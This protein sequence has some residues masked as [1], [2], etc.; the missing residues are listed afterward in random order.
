MIPNRI[1][2]IGGSTVYGQG[3]PHGGG[4]VGRLRAWHEGSSPE[5][6]RVFNLGIGGDGV[7]EMLFRGS[8]EISARRAELIILY[9]GLNDTRR[10]GSKNNPTQTELNYF[11]STLL[12]LITTLLTQA[13][14][15]LMSPVPIDEQKTCPYRSKWFFTQNDAAE[16]ANIIS[17]LAKE[18]NIPY[19]PVFETW[20][21]RSN[22]KNLLEDGLHCNSE[23]HQLLFGE[24]QALLNETYIDN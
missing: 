16:I 20:I 24:L 21:R 8:A 23:G 12:N 6:N 10:I 14:L 7:T 18:L 22:L 5:V 2:V 4:F 17:R 13:P 11:E 9:P 1:I 3:D 15:V 19:L